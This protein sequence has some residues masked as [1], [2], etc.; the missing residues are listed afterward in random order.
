MKATN[1]R[2]QD[3]RVQR[4]GHRRRVLTQERAGQKVSERKSRGVDRLMWCVVD[5]DSWDVIFHLTGSCGKD[6]RAQAQVA[7]RDTDNR[8]F[9]IIRCGKDLFE[10]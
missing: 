2:G 7:E 1:S 4:P 3:L 5:P 9:R 10:V 8:D 6:E